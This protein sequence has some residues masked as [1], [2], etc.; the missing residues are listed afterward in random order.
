MLLS[1]ELLEQI[2]LFGFELELHLVLCLVKCVAYFLT[3][4]QLL[5]EDPG[6]ADG[7]LV[8]DVLLRLDA[9]DMLHSTFLEDPA[10][11]LRVTSSH[12]DEVEVRKR[13]CDELAELP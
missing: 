8:Q 10:N 13:R 4:H 9:D 7:S 11:K 3:F 1:G 6:E 5:V 2:C 12:E